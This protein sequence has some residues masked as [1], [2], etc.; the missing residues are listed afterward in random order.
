MLSALHE[1][2]DL[3]SPSRNT[4]VFIYNEKGSIAVYT[5]ITQEIADDLRSQEGYWG[6]N[7]GPGGNI[8]DSEEYF[9]ERFPGEPLPF[10]TAETWCDQVFNYPDWEDVTQ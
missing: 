7:L 8:Y 1:G 10:D 6:G 2:T 5:S 4:Y 9:E 3:Y